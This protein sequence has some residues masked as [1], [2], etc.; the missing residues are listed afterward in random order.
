LPELYFRVRENGA[1]V[2][3]VDTG[4]RNAR[5]EMEQI[6]VVN[7]RNGEIKGHGGRALSAEETAAIEAWRDERQAVLAAREVDD[8]MRTVDQLNLAA[9]WAQQ[10]ASPKELERITDALLMAMH[11]LRAVL[12]RKSLD[13]QGPD[14][15]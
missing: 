12:V 10:K 11:D 6:A 4:N 7:V 8:I 3:R 9:A 5:I 13:R 15:D 14:G 1:A 2:F